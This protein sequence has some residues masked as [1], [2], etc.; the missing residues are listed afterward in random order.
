[1]KLIILCVLGSF[2]LGCASTPVPVVVDALGYDPINAVTMGCD[3]PY[4][5]TQDCSKWMGANRKISVEGRDIRIAGSKDGQVILVMGGHLAKNSLKQSLLRRD[6]SGIEANAS[7]EA[8]KTVLLQHDIKISRVRA[9]MIL[10]RINGY[11]F[12]VEGD[13]YGVLKAYTEE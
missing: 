13:G 11:V 7:F 8:V 1:M 6:Y 12:D 3:K 5:L 2:A 10:G 9:V 4:E